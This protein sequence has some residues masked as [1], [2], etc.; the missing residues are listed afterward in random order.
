MARLLGI[1]N[2]HCARTT[3]AG[4]VSADGTHIEFDT[5]DFTSDTAVLWTI[6]P[7]RI[8]VRPA[9]QTL[10]VDASLTVVRATLT[11]LA[12]VGTAV[13]LYVRLGDDTELHARLTNTVDLAVGDPCTVAMRREDIEVW[14]DLGGRPEVDV[15]LEGPTN[16]SR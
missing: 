4:L 2:L 11:D 1:S 14:R 5:G 8:D 16:W 9:R 7:E 12:D 13:D 10:D 6:R 15:T 3:D